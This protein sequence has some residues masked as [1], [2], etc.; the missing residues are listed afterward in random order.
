MHF[1]L[2]YCILISQ[3]TI[4]KRCVTKLFLF[5]PLAA[6]YK[7]FLKEI[8]IIILVMPLYKIQ[9]KW[10]FDLFL[11]GEAAWESQ[12]GKSYCSSLNATMHAPFPQKEIWF[13]FIPTP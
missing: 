11:S 1:F 6:S 8:I 4:F 7:G 13:S 2:L 5:F 9:I 3:S 12:L 10:W